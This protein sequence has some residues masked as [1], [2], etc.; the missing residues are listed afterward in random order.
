V[1][2]RP[3]PLDD[4]DQSAFSSTARPAA[5]AVGVSSKHAGPQL[6]RGGCVLRPSQQGRAAVAAGQQKGGAGK[7]GELLLRELRKATV[8]VVA[9][10]DDDSDLPDL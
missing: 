8:T 10:G 6:S 1:A 3:R 5:V 2:F 9:A 4:A 7:E